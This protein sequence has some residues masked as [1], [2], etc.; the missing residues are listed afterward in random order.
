MDT[1]SIN[2]TIN[3]VL[4]PKNPEYIRNWSVSGHAMF[5]GLWTNEELEIIIGN[6]KHHY[7]YCK[8]DLLHILRGVGCP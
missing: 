1:F 7:K 4:T 2:V 5:C 6:S 8:T 3:Y